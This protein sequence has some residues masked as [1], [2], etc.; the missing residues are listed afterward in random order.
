MNTQLTSRHSQVDVKPVL[1]LRGSL[2]PSALQSK[3]RQSS[4]LLPPPTPTPTPS[5]P[6]TSPTSGSNYYWN[7]V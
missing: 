3:G 7:L 6:T 1:R 5:T 4:N 2:S